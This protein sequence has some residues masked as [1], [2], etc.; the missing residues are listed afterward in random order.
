MSQVRPTDHGARV[1]DVS[2]MFTDVRSFTFFLLART[3][4]TET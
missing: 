3:A 1:A 4:D 2:L